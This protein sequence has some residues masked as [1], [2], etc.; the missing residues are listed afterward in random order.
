MM[1][2]AQ[3]ATNFATSAARTAVRAKRS[4]VWLEAKRSSSA[5]GEP[6]AVAR[7]MPTSASASQFHPNSVQPPASLL[8]SHA[9]WR[10]TRRSARY[11]GPAPSSQRRG[12][13]RGPTGSLPSSLTTCEPQAAHPTCALSAECPTRPRWASCSPTSPDR[14]AAPPR[15]PSASLCRNQSPPTTTPT[16]VEPCVCQRPKRLMGGCNSAAEPM[17]LS[18]QS[19]SAPLTPARQRQM[20]SV[21]RSHHQPTRPHLA[22]AQPQPLTSRSYATN[23][24][25]AAA[26]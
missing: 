18:R 1:W 16:P 21:P 10:G 22:T 17:L 25:R 23:S 2:G 20:R 19:G 6:A 5:R 11:T 8:L 3:Q 24:Q 14:Q 13:V 9:T 7:L 15:Q 4:S 12:P 26:A